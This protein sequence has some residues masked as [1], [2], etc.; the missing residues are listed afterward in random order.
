MALKIKP[1]GK[2]TPR[3]Q[4]SD[5]RIC[6]IHFS[7]TVEETIMPAA[8]EAFNKITSV[9]QKRLTFSDV[10]HKLPEVSEL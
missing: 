5:G 9:A 7:S 4:G 1:Q 6:I 2:K 8:E 10:T 3:T